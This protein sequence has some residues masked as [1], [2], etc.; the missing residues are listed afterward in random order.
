MYYVIGIAKG[1]T[2]VAGKGIYEYQ[3]LAVYRSEQYVKVNADA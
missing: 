3:T 1:D 2:K